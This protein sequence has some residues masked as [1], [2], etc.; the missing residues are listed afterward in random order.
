MTL[1]ARSVNGLLKLLNQFVAHLGFPG[2]GP[3]RSSWHLRHL[4]LLGSKNND[5]AEFLVMI[6]VVYLR[7][8]VIRCARCSHFVPLYQAW[9]CYAEHS[10]CL[11]HFDLGWRSHLCCDF[12]TSR[13][14][15]PGYWVHRPQQYYRNFRAQ[16]WIPY[17][18]YP[19]QY[20]ALELGIA[21]HHLQAWQR[22]L[23]DDGDI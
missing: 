22:D 19:D 13:G 17:P 15:A 12:D 5:V 8:L 9:H 16:A 11:R 7:E 20:S 21:V 1:Q 3:G 2:E 10:F 6:G 18:I 14:C 23:H 4:L